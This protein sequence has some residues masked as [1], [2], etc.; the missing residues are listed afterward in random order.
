VADRVPPP[1][2]DPDDMVIDVNTK[3][4][5]VEHGGKPDPFVSSCE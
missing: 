2:I 5:D 3:L 4:T 1:N